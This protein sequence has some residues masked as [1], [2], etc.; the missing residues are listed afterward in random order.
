[1]TV[2]LEGVAPARLA[3]IFAVMHTFEL[4][5]PEPDEW[6]ADS[7]RISAYYYDRGYLQMKVTGPV[8]I[9]SP[10]GLS[11][12]VRF[13]VEEGRPFR[14]REYVVFEDVDGSRREPLGHWKASLGPGDVFSRGAVMIDFDWLRR[15]Y[16]DA[17]YAEVVAEPETDLDAPGSEVTLRSRIVRGELHT[18]GRIRIVGL[19]KVS[20]ADVRRS[21]EAVEGQRFSESALLR[22][23]EALRT[24]RLFDRIAVSTG[25]GQTPTQDDVTFEVEERRR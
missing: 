5:E 4:V 12:R 21:I 24:T 13:T 18:F 2:E 1:M 9:P 19:K 16:R 6:E 23:K 7:Y 11:F 3:D 25:P 14:I 15:I 22:S 10:D 8:V 17:G 20:E